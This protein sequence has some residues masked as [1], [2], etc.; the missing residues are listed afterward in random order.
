MTSRPRMLFLTSSSLLLLVT[1]CS[2]TT[3]K[4][5]LAFQSELL[6]LAFKTATALPTEPH[7][8][9]RSRAQESVV[10]T[11]FQLDQPHRAAG[12]IQGIDNWRRGLAYADLALY[13]AQHE[14]R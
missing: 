6:D 13:C 5:L 7:I 9:N 3:D 1:A 12:Y 2:D 10:D 14:S 4:P 11:C 8:K